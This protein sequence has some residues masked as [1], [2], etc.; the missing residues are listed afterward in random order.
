M[1]TKS[2][3]FSQ[4]TKSN[5]YETHRDQSYSSSQ[6]DN[7]PTS[8][9][10]NQ[11]PT[12]SGSD[13]DFIGFSSKYTSSNYAS[14]S[15]SSSSPNN[16]ST[17]LS[18]SF[19]QSN[20][21]QFGPLNDPQNL[22]MIIINDSH[23]NAIMNLLNSNNLNEQISGNYE[24]DF[25]QDSGTN[26]KVKDTSYVPLD[27]LINSSFNTGKGKGKSTLLISE[28][29][30]ILSSLSS[31]DLKERNYLESLISLPESESILHY[32]QNNSYTEDIYGV[33]KK[34]SELLK[35]VD[36]DSSGGSQEEAGRV[37]AL[38]R[39]GA[40]MQHVWGR[41][42][43]VGESRRSSAGSSMEIDSD[44]LTS[45]S[46]TSNFSPPINSTSN[47][48]HSNIINGR[49]EWDEDNAARSS[50]LSFS[51]RILNPSSRS[52][53]Y[54]TPYLATLDNSLSIPNPLAASFFPSNSSRLNS[55]THGQKLKDDQLSH[56]IHRMS[57]FKL[58]PP[59]SPTSIRQ[60]VEF[61][62]LPPH[63]NN[64]KGANRIR[65]E[66]QN[67]LVIDLDSDS[68]GEEEVVRER[69]HNSDDE[70]KRGRD[71][72]P[73]FSEFMESKLRMLKDGKGL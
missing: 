24:E 15:T 41:E 67:R 9:F 18:S 68:E 33:Q 29:E 26:W 16:Y 58:S 13:E 62:Q 48:N 47:S 10:R 63:L 27:P 59:H 2:S 1:S 61:N 66:D 36:S 35:L 50:S 19:N 71:G 73:P 25:F 39:L 21:Q 30:I 38:R 52:S 5:P 46:T 23:P 70:D 69:G 53:N 44:P 60:D 72:L 65:E 3:T 17:P 49:S 51:N 6:Y 14:T 31:L 12:G 20:N 40:V 22:N 55:Q 7:R 34:V 43:I 56:T 4:L 32:L 64:N 57:E 11:P 37:K 54:T 8:S 42:S 28:E 45:T